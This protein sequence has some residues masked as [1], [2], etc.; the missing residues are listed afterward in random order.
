LSPNSIFHICLDRF[1]NSA[2][3]IL[4]VCS[5]NIPRTQAVSSSEW[6]FS[7]PS[8]VCGAIMFWIVTWHKGTYEGNQT[9]IF[10]TLLHPVLQNASEWRYN[11]C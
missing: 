3:V 7:W 8:G 10:D 4:S 1:S 9:W 2:F 6:S 5:F 11:F